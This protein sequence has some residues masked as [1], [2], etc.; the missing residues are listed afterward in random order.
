MSY[1]FT[2]R[3]KTLLYVLLCCV[4][5]V[6]GLMLLI[7]PALTQLNDVEMQLQDKRFSQEQMSQEIAQAEAYH[8]ALQSGRESLASSALS[9]YAPMTADQADQLVTGMLLKH[10]LTPVS[11]SISA[12]ED[13]AVYPYLTEPPEPAAQA[14]TANTEE[15]PS[16]AAAADT[17][18]DG[19]GAADGGTAAPTA[20]AAPT[21]PPAGALTHFRL[22]A[23]MTGKAASFIDLCDETSRLPSLRIVGF[24]ADAVKEQA[25]ADDG[26]S[27]EPEFTATFEL[28]MYHPAPQEDDYETAAS[29]TTEE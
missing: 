21:V 10:G 18:A 15:I 8:T 28:L 24:T 11:L 4:I 2:R 17:A 29:E 16:E 14:D 5:V 13:A 22:E 9:F 6:A 20:A 23:T 1:Q 3:E 19:T 25:A 7:F 12:A 26:G 27:Y